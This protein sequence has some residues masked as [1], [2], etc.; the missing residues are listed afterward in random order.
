MAAKSPSAAA[1]APGTGTINAPLAILLV[2]LTTLAFAASD[3]IGKLLFDRTMQ[4]ALEEDC[5]GMMWQVLNWNAPAINFYR[6]YGAKLD[7]EWTNCSLE[8]NQIEAL[9]N[10]KKTRPTCG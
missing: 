4:K 2:V 7:N 10:Q 5:S 1:Q 8:R 9:V 3:V 6:K